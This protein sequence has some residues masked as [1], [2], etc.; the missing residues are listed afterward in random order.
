MNVYASL[1]SLRTFS[2]LEVNRFNE[3]DFFTARV[4]EKLN[5]R[6]PV[7]TVQTTC[8][9]SAIAIIQACQSLLNYQCDMALAGGSAITL[10]QKTGYFYQEGGISSPDGHCRAF[11]ASARGTTG[12]SGAGVVVLKRLDDALAD[13]DHIEAIIRG[14]GINNDGA[15]KVGFT[16]PSIQGQAEAISMAQTM[17]GVSADDISYIE[18]HGTGTVMGDPIEVGA[19]TQV[20]RRTS[21]RKN[22]CGLG[23]VK[24]NIGHCNSAAGVAGL[25]K[26]V[27][28]LKHRMLPPSLHFVRPNPNIDFDNSPFYV[29]DALRPWEPG[30]RP[31]L[32]GVSSFGIGG[33]NGHL[34]L[35]EAPDAP[36]PSPSRSYQLI[37]LSA[38]SAAAL[39]N[40]CSRLQQHLQQ[41]PDLS[42]PD[43]AYTL[44]TGRKRFS[45]RKI[46]VLP[47][48][49]ATAGQP[50]LLDNNLHATTETDD[51]QR[52]QVVFL[53]PGQ[54]AQY[55]NMGKGLY[56]HEPLFRQIVD[57]C[58]HILQPL[59]GADLRTLMYNSHADAAEQLKQTAIAQ[60]A[61]FVTSYATAKLWMSWGVKPDIMIGHSIG[62]LAAACVA[63]KTSLE[64]ALV[65]TIKTE[66]IADDATTDDGCA[67]I[68]ANAIVIEILPKSS[69]ANIQEKMIYDLGFC[70]LA[71]I[72]IDWTTFY[73]EEKRQKTI[74]PTY[75]FE[76]TRYWMDSSWKAIDDRELQKNTNP[77]FHFYTDQWQAS[78]HPSACY[79]DNIIDEGTSYLVFGDMS[80]FCDELISGLRSAGK[81]VFTVT[82]GN[83]FAIGEENNF[84]LDPCDI[85]HM[86]QFFKVLSSTQARFDTILHLYGF[87]ERGLQ[88][89]HKTEPEIEQALIPF[90]SLVQIGKGLIDYHPHSDIQLKVIVSG[91]HRF[92]QLEHIQSYKSLVT[93]ACHLIEKN[94]PGL[95]WQTID[96]DYHLFGGEGRKCAVK[97]LLDEF[98]F[99]PSQNQLILRNNKRFKPVQRRQPI[100]GPIEP[101]GVRNKHTYLFC[102]TLSDAAYA[103]ADEITKNSKS[104]SIFVLHKSLPAE[105]GWEQRTI[106]VEQH[107]DSSGLIPRLKQ[108]K[109]CG[110]AFTVLRTDL[111]ILKNVE[112]LKSQSLQECGSVDGIFY[113]SDP[114]KNNDGMEE[115][116]SRIVT[117]AKT[118]GNLHK[119]FSEQKLNDF[120]MFSFDAQS[121]SFNDAFAREH[122]NRFGIQYRSIYV[123][124]SLE[125]SDVAQ[126]NAL[127][128]VHKRI[129]ATQ[130]PQIMV[131]IVDPEKVVSDNFI[132]NEFAIQN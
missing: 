75:P 120:T 122:Y 43:L 16:A 14:F 21:N 74:L 123:H 46:Y 62:E 119:M 30:D 98:N 93:A 1:D 92:H 89:N 33:T 61:I 17:A 85:N 18:A 37:T 53:F 24:T 28:A 27:L 50:H 113:F 48:D 72:D 118:I 108:W 57:E 88:S 4:A 71:G 60:P 114:E 78:A 22:Y 35:Q 41:H 20:F 128:S 32:A 10:P 66:D 23:S 106:E 101:N 5:L 116:S 42:L 109:E 132:M 77:N 100:A 55:V 3:K 69:T 82:S 112:Q 84:T 38:R 86:D 96:V 34:V 97:E 117:A 36:L 115:G 130:L 31:R 11:D 13:R 6:G 2:R 12:G 110:R 126:A 81:K 26:T 25:I 127:V 19:L 73:R 80:Q 54:G 111:T 45:H 90:Y 83:E 63:E 9:T 76:R 104:H 107:D 68:A 49:A 129:K 99:L 131:T 94:L 44:Q 95:R 59:I 8:S 56:D 40:M 103:F 7:V 39:D 125:F 102:G 15:E 47:S 51:T 91:L 87:E 52:K 79:D 121:R 105:D 65:L 29:V 64:E 70:W 124:F 58:C 67:N